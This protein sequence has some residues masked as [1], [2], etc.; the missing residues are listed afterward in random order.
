MHERICARPGRPAARTNPNWSYPCSRS[1]VAVFAS[2]LVSYVRSNRFDGIDL[3]IEQH[4][5][6]GSL[7]L[8]A[9]DL[10]AC[11][12]A[13]YDDANAAKSAPA[14]KPLVTSDVDAT[15]DSDIGRIQNDDDDRC[16]VNAVAGQAP[17]D[18]AR[19][20]AGD[21]SKQRWVVEDRLREV[22]PFASNPIVAG[23]PPRTRTGDEPVTCAPTYVKVCRR[24]ITHPTARAGTAV[25]AAPWEC[26]RS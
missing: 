24:A 23:M 21:I 6:T 8:T 3:D 4:A 15:T 10:R 20:G 26:R 14:A 25:A 22:A 1:N 2:D 13:V 18:D 7:V 9:A 17:V 12:Q 19:Q 5:G 11:T 16:G